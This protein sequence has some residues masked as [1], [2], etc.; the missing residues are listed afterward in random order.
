M[1]KK[2]RNDN[3]D[4]LTFRPNIRYIEPEQQPGEIDALPPEVPIEDIRAEKN[5]V[6]RLAE[7]V[8]K[9]ATAVQAKADERAK[10]MKIKLDPKVD[11]PTIAAMKRMHP[12]AD[13]TEITYEQYRQC[14][15]RLRA[16]G[17]ELGKRAAISM[18]DVRNAANAMSSDAGVLAAAS[19]MGGFNTKAA[20]TGGLR[21]EL[22]ENAQIIEP[23]DI[24]EF[25]DFLIRTLINFVWKNFIKP[26]LPLPPGIG[27]FMIP[28]EIAPLP[29]GMSTGDLVSMGVPVLGEKKK[30]Q[31]QPEVPEDAEVTI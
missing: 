5:K 14:K 6:K 30:K 1:S 12:D 11:A 7:T 16:K 19:Q 13:P 27:S 22:D 15:D 23:L 17:E 10:G 8:N 25:Q 29:G 2:L 21:P 31:E 9:L 26:V 28:D 20:R 3:R 18:D 4:I 24:E